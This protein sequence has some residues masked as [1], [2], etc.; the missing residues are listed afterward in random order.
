MLIVVPPLP[1]RGNAAR[2]VQRGASIGHHI[3]TRFLG[4]LLISF[5]ERI[6]L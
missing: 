2:V 1:Y 3:T 4:F 5:E 6:Q